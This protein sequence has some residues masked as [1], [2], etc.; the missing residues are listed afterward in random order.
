MLSWPP[1]YAAEL[2]RLDYLQ[3]VIL[4]YLV[5]FCNAG[6]GILDRP[7][8]DLSANP[9]GLEQSWP[10]NPL[11][12]PYPDRNKSKQILGLSRGQMR[13][14]LELITGQ[15]N[16]NYVQ[17]KIYPEEI[18]PLCRFCEEEDETF[19]HLLNECPCFNTYRREILLNQSV[20]S[21]LNWRAK[22][23]LQFSY[24]PQIDKALAWE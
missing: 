8:H 16:L 24:I 22:T 12:L 21:T 18:S 17:N 9:L 11:I 1:S 20:I 10:R 23:L 15:S 5:P 6:L 2:Q 3:I 4:I 14:L 13:R 7:N 19:A